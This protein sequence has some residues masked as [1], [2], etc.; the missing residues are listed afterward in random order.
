M[1]PS[2]KPD[3]VAISARFIAMKPAT[4]LSFLT[5]GGAMGERTRAVDWSHTAA[6]LP[7][8]R[9]QSQKTAMR[10]ASETVV[11]YAR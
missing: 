3:L 8:R 2:D 6:G 4:N 10:S 1:G 11:G 9:P 5:G 7:A